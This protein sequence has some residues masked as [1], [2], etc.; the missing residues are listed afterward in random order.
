VRLILQITPFSHLT[1]IIIISAYFSHSKKGRQMKRREQCKSIWSMKFNCHTLFWPLLLKR[2]KNLVGVRNP[3]KQKKNIFL[4]LHFSEYW[5][6]N[7][8]SK[9]VRMKWN[10]SEL[11]SKG[12]FLE[13]QESSL[14]MWSLHCGFKKKS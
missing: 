1:L 7:A 9:W 11:H 14:C 4:Q 3:G 8:T 6:E 2:I 13:K 12:T 10:G 5:T